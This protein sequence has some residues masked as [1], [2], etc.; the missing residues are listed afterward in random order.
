VAEEGCSVI[1]VT[2]AAGQKRQVPIRVNPIPARSD[3]PS[4]IYVRPRCRYILEAARVDGAP[5]ELNRDI[6]ANYS[7]F[8]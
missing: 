2:V 8:K 6:K 3:L 1:A 4:C 7:A 5:T